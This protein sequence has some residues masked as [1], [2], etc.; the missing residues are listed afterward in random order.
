MDDV[1]VAFQ[2]H[3]AFEYDAEADEA[4]MTA[5]PFDA[6]ARGDP[7]ANTSDENTSDDGVAFTVTLE[8]PTLSAAVEEAV[9][10]AVESGWHD[11]FE[12][13]AADA[14][15]VAKEAAGEVRVERTTADGE[16][17]VRVTLEFTAPARQGVADAAAL[18]NFLEGTYLQG[19]IP[20][21]TYRDPVAGLLSTARQRGQGETQTGETQSS[22]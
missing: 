15:D 4:R 1:Q 20:G 21:Y 9:G 3:E 14:Y 18:V 10:D 8:A 17:A 5:T 6:V 12:R 7:D 2:G 19:T 22:E 13:R 11:T 16:A